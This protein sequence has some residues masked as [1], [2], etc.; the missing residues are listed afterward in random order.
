MDKITIEH[1][2]GQITQYEVTPCIAE[3]IEMLVANCGCSH[4]VIAYE[5]KR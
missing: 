5:K 4:T 1:Q 3:A 2:N